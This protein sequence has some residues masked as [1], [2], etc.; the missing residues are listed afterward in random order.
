MEQK[1]FTVPN[2][3][4][5]GCVKSIVGELTQMTGVKKV[6]GDVASKQVTVEWDKPAT[7]DGIRSALA[8]IDYPAAEPA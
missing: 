4:C 1:T 5:N 8:A 7:W 6:S 3:G 2:I